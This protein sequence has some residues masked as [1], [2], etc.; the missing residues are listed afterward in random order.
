MKEVRNLLFQP[1]T[2]HLAG[3]SLHL[4][5]RQR[6]VISADMVTPELQQAARRGLVRLVDRPCEPAQAEPTAA[7]TTK[8]RKRKGRN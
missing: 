1:L 3:Q 5:P 7:K 2:F 4:L 8:K 6:R